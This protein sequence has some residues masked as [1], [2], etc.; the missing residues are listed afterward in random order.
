MSPDSLESRV[1]R[2]E[3]HL[4]TV[5]QRV[6]DLAG[7]VS[8]LGHI[9]DGQIRLEAEARHVSAELSRLASSVEHV[10]RRMKDREDAEHALRIKQLE[11]AAKHR[12]V[13]WGGIGAIVA[14]CITT[15]AAIFQSAP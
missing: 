6:D 14:A 10:R 2:I 4:A 8:A 7:D 1:N 11:D 9:G 3:Q 5:T 13:M 12:K 15:V